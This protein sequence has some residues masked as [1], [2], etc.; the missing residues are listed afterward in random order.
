MDLVAAPTA[1]AS[2][3]DEELPAELKGLD[4]EAQAAKVKQLAEEKK[5][6]EEKAAKLAADRDAWRA[7]NVSE[8]E[9]AFDANVMKG[10]KAQA[11][12]HGL[13]Y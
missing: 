2:V 11:A 3:R 13:T 9:D 1:L 4:K 7:K 8:K 6:L 10:V 12:K 5:V